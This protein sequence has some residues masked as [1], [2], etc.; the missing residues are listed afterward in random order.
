VSP[1]IHE[2][3]TIDQQDGGGVPWFLRLWASVVRRAA[4]DWVLYKD[5]P[6]TK[7]RKIGNDAGF[8]IF[9]EE[10]EN[11]LSSFCCVCDILGLD[12]EFMR[13]KIKAMT[14]EQARCLRGMEFGD[15]W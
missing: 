1:L 5:H 4:V 9:Q 14:E 8:W 13:S 2:T 11:R 3:I 12:R 6:N 7:F 15:E 10:D